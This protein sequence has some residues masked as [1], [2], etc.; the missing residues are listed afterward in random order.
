M[1]KFYKI[2]HRGASGYEP[3]NTLAA[4]SKALE[5]KAD[6]IELDVRLSK[7][8]VP[9]VIHDSTVSRTSNGEGLVRDLS[10]S[11]LREFDFGNGERIPTLENVF[12][13]FAGKTLI[14]IEL[15]EY[16]LAAVVRELIDR[17][18]AW[19]SIV[20]SAFDG[21][22]CETEPF[23]STWTELFWLKRQDARIK[24]SLLA[25][26]RRG[27]GLALNRAFDGDIFSVNISRAAALTLPPP[28]VAGLL[29]NTPVW[30]YTVDDAII[31]NRLKKIG[32]NGIFS[33]YPDRV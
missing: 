16:G 26:T 30:V 22:E 15:K 24:I 13:V 5:L 20:V 7:D 33:N 14:V 10:F 23:S 28:L 4:F 27:I 21:D 2:A 25:R 19:N 3:E 1:E 32:V 8:G 6:G 29:G 11:Q 12:E 31:A 9:V 18:K 17:Y